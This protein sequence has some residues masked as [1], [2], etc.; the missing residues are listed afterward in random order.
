MSSAWWPSFPQSVQIRNLAPQFLLSFRGDPEAAPGT[1][2]TIRRSHLTVFGLAQR[3]E[4]GLTY[5]LFSSIALLLHLS[6]YQPYTLRRDGSCIS[7]ISAAV[8]FPQYCSC[9]CG[10]LPQLLYLPPLH[11]PSQYCSCQ[12]QV[13]FCEHN[14]EFSRLNNRPQSHLWMLMLQRLHRITVVKASSTDKNGTTCNLRKSAFSD[15]PADPLRSPD[16]FLRRKNGYSAIN[17]SR[18]GHPSNAEAI[19]G[20]ENA[21]TPST[22]PFL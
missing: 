3:S 11:L 16:G 1:E 9:R 14:S 2:F 13:R 7:C 10:C 6:I 5:L 22:G 17:S 19:K 15:R 4:S 20:G 12:L 21:Y 8:A 18:S